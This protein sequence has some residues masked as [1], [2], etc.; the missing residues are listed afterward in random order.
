MLEINENKQQ[1]AHRNYYERK[2]SGIYHIPLAIDELSYQQRM[3]TET[4]AS[5]QKNENCINTHQIQ[6]TNLNKQC[7]RP[8]KKNLLDSKY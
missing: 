5:T 6:E 3:T 7:K 1:E 4:E 2:L 8:R